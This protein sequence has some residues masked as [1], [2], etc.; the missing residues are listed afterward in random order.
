MA[1]KTG[2]G[3]VVI[4]CKGVAVL[5]GRGS[6]VVGV[7]VAVV[8]VEEAGVAGLTGEEAFPFVPATFGLDAAAAAAGEAAGV[9]LAAVPVAGVVAG[10]A[11]AVVAAGVAG[12]PGVVAAVRFFFCAATCCSRILSFRCVTR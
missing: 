1:G 10:L 3:S 9:D 6:A 11:S 8:L 5:G 4:E 2:F 7:T 12:L